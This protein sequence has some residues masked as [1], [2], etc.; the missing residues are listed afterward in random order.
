MGFLLIEHSMLRNIYESDHD[1]TIIINL[2]IITNTSRYSYISCYKNLRKSTYITHLL[3]HPEITS[4]CYVIVPGILYPSTRSRYRS[5]I[6]LLPHSRACQYPIR[7]FRS[8]NWHRRSEISMV[9]CIPLPVLKIRLF[10]K[11]ITLSIVKP[12]KGGKGD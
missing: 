12:E 3:I 6:I 1:Y 4:H 9:T 7:L 11:Q 10:R 8:N 5:H 2:T